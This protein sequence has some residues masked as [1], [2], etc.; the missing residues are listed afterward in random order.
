[1]ANAKDDSASI[2]VSKTKLEKFRGNDRDTLDIETWC[3]QICRLNTVNKLGDENTAI[4]FMEALR[5]Q[6]LS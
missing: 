6:A 1:M 4:I 3:L 2:D 5:E